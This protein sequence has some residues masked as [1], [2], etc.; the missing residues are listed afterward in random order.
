VKKNIRSALCLLLVSAV[1]WGGA[2][3]GV[4]AR[5]AKEAGTEYI[6]KYKESAEG[7]MNTDGR[8]PFDVVSEEEMER[9]RQAGLLAWYEPNGEAILL[10]ADPEAACYDEAQWNLDVIHAEG[11]FRQGHLGQGVLVGVIDSGIAPHPALEANLLPGHNY[12]ENAADPDETGDSYG[13]GTRVAGLIAAADD[14][15]YI[16]AAPGAKL[17]P[18]KVTDGSSVSISTVCEAIY[19]G[20]D[21]Y[22][23]NIL[24]LSLGITRDYE[25]I[26]EAVAYA[27]ERGVVVVA[28]VGNDGDAALYYPAAYDTVIGAGSVD[29]D[30]LISSGS[31]HN[32]SVFVTAPG[33]AVRTTAASGGYT[34]GTGT[35]FSVPQ[36]AAAAAVLRGI[37][38]ALTPEDIRTLIAG[39]AEDRGEEGYDVYYGHGILDLAGCVS[40][41]MAEKKESDRCSFLPEEGAATELRNNTDETVRCAYFLTEY[42]ES[43]RC[44]KVTV[45]PYELAPGET[46]AIEAPAD[47]AGFGQFVCE[48]DTMIPLTAARKT[49]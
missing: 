31:N 21:D 24:N 23:C 43:G 9:L 6:V 47:G 10:D 20:I 44:V 39:S 22:E 49:L 34:T 5:A 36:A 15:G 17:V 27:E 28:A 13:H 12:M 25:S 32:E 30:G 48:A 16:G 29:K 42:D 38:G 40:A 2:A 45:R 35:S 19:G 33:V 7:I 11:A 41:L 8:V 18:L 37:D 3:G 26:R 1:F 4:P 14:G 46:A